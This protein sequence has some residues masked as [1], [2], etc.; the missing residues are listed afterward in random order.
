MNVNK[1][2]Y[3]SSNALSILVSTAVFL[4]L[5]A[6]M[7]V[8]DPVSAQSSCPAACRSNSRECNAV[9][10]NWSTKC[11]AMWVGTS[12]NWI[13][14]AY[15]DKC[16]CGGCLAKCNPICTGTACRGGSGTGG[17]GGTGGGSTTNP[18]PAVTNAPSKV[19]TT[20]EPVQPDGTAGVTGDCSGNIPGTPDGKVDLQDLEYL[21]RELNKEVSTRACDFDKSGETDIIDFTNYFREGFV[22]ASRG[23][24]TGGGTVIP[25]IQPNVTTT[26]PTRPTTTPVP[27]V[28]ATVTPSSQA[29]P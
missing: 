11:P 3:N 17:T 8:P 22:N 24:N 26:V 19:P 4:G 1:H 18:G 10:N 13:P 27:S 5:C 12:C 7:L 6:L 23:G 16:N 29:R 15:R 25:T 14:C 28:N 9:S 21:R 2:T 20:T